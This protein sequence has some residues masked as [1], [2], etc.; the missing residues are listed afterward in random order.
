MSAEEM[1]AV[2]AATVALVQLVKWMGL[3]DNRGPLV[4]M[5]LALLGVV[6]WGVST[7][8]AFDRS[9]I[10]PYFAAWI[11]IA[12]SAAG[13]FGFTRAAA[14]AVTST[15]VPASGAGSSPTT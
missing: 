3:P 15:K 11:M 7:E 2:A 12:T 10:W 14:T 8:D 9:L 4:V 1:A 5:L 6:L 13:I